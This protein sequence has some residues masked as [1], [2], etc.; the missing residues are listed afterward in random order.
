MKCGVTG[1]T[2]VAGE[3]MAIKISIHLKKIATQ[4]SKFI[5]FKNF[6]KMLKNTKFPGIFH[7]LK[8]LNFLVAFYFCPLSLLIL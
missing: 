1:V 4:R 2:A 8:I 3:I 6:E 7:Q 5:A